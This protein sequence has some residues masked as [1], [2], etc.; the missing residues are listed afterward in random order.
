MKRFS[1]FLLVT[2]G[3]AVIT[4]LISGMNFSPDLRANKELYKE[5]REKYGSEIKGCKHCHVGALPKEDDHEF[6]ERGK[7]LM[8]QKEKRNADKV[9][10]SWLDEYKGN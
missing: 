7:W 3:F 4:L 5:A 8:E 1:G 6:N 10:V 2:V 9:D